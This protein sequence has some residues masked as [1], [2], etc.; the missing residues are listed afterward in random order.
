MLTSIDHENKHLLFEEYFQNRTL[1]TGS[2]EDQHILIDN[3]NESSM[4]VFQTLI[5]E[6]KK[7]SLYN[8]DNIVHELEDFKKL[9]ESISEIISSATKSND[10]EFL[11]EAFSMTFAVNDKLGS[12]QKVEKLENTNKSLLLDF[13]KQNEY[14]IEYVPLAVDLVFNYITS[15]TVEKYKSQDELICKLNSNMLASM[16]S[17]TL[18]NHIGAETYA[19]KYMYSC[20]AA[21]KLKDISNTYFTFLTKDDSALKHTLAWYKVAKELHPKP[22]YYYKY[23]QALLIFG[24]KQEAVSNL[25]EAIVVDN[26]STEERELCETLLSELE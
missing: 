7:A 10:L 25:Q 13:Y 6:M 9:S 17:D 26:I 21:K 2:F 24:Q 22:S 23:A 20:K 16:D 18:E 14:K 15:H 11:Q 5:S 1:D 8:F 3:F 12:A 4:H 19:R